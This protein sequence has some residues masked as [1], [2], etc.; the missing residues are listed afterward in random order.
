MDRKNSKNK[1]MMSSGIWNQ[2]N[3]RRSLSPTPFKPKPAV[4]A[5]KPPNVTHTPIK[6]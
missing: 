3:K 6:G 5:H 4:S 1:Q 2:N